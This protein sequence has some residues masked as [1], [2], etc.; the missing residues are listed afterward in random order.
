MRIEYDEVDRECF[1]L[2]E[3]GRAYLEYNDKVGGE[4]FGYCV[5]MPVEPM[6]KIKELGGIAAM[7]QECIRLGKTW[8]EL[9]GWD[10]HS[11]EMPIPQEYFEN[12]SEG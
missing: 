9:L 1:S 12:G 7:Y 5:G 3:V 6:D 4:P 8:E 10:G 2:S 11:D